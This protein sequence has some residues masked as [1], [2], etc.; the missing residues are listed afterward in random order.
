MK[1]KLFSFNMEKKKAINSPKKHFGYSFFYT[2][3]F[4]NFFCFATF[5]GEKFKRGEKMKKVNI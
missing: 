3:V 2:L 5:Y 4:I 1:I